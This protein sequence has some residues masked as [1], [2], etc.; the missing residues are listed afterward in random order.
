MMLL[1]LP[2]LSVSPFCLLLCSLT[3][4]YTIADNVEL[5]TACGKLHRVS[6]LAITDAGKAPP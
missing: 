1:E 4:L 2:C 5:G 6:V 3:L